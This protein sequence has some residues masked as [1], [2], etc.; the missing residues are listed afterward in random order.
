LQNLFHFFSLSLTHSSFE[1]LITMHRALLSLG[2]VVITAYLLARKKRNQGRLRHV[3]ARGEKVLIFGCSS[4][5]GKALALTYAQRGAKLILVARRQALL[6]TLAEECQSLG[7]TFA[8]GLAGDVTDVASMEKV[9]KE[10]S[11]RFE[12]TVDTVVYCAGAIS[13]RP[14]MESSGIKMSGKQVVVDKEQGQ[15]A[16]RALH[17]ITTINYFAAVHTTRLVLPMLL[18]S[19]GQPNLMVISSMAG[20]VGAPTRAMYSGSKHAV[21]GFFD[22]LRVEMVPFNI[23]VG[24]VCPG[25]VDTELRQSAV[26]LG[27]G[28]SSEIAGTT[29]GKLSPQAVADRILLASDRREREVYIPG[30]YYWALWVAR[31]WIDALAQKK[32]RQKDS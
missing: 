31:S 22:S 21:H 13:V 24:L 12:G 6:T 9:V 32:Y 28:S 15:E 19:S 26:D 23:H 17:A 20:K 27:S 14:F 5:I 8:W 11:L 2:V 18:A 16:D 3:P 25:T 7:A 4:G 29:K 10:A 30:Y 1:H